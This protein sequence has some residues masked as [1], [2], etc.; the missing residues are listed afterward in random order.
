MT[1]WVLL[2]GLMRESRHWGSF[3][4]TFEQHVAGARTVCL[5]LPGSG[6]L[7][8]Q[9]SPSS[10][11]GMV[12]AYR[13]MLAAARLE[14][15]Y[16]LLALSLGAMVA[17]AWAHRH[18]QELSGMV[19]MNTSLRPFSPFYRRLRWRNYP[20]LLR[21]ALSN[22]DAAASER[23]ILCLTSR[24][25][26][27]ESDADIVRAWAGYRQE[28]PV[29]RR[30]ALRQ[31]SAAASYRAPLHAPP[32]RLLVLAG[33][34]DQLVDPACS[35][36]LARAWHADFALHPAAGHD[37]PLDDGRWVAEQVRRWL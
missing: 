13:G 9:A 27:A 6:R 1:T 8:A 24:L 18:A 3:P 25:R 23:L 37:L 36:R 7:H 10:V 17:V 30:N 4:A 35:I 5:D 15:P 21:L 26:D 11:E 14:P 16:Y 33:G 12:D 31:L 28:C 32:T 34:A 29:A 20:A 22:G 19:L 2:R